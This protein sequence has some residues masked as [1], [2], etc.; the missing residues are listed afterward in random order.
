LEEKVSENINN[1]SSMSTVSIDLTQTLNHS[2]DMK[3]SSAIIEFTDKRLEKLE[4]NDCVSSTSETD[5]WNK[6]PNNH[7]ESWDL[8][9]LL[10]NQ[11]DNE[12]SIRLDS[13]G[14]DHE[15]IVKENTDKQLSAINVLHDVA[16]I[17]E[18]K[19]YSMTKELTS[20]KLLT[21]PK[22]R[23]FLAKTRRRLIRKRSKPCTRLDRKFQAGWVKK[24]NIEECWIVLDAYDPNYSLKNS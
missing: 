15:T 10:R 23:I 21:I 9:G 11:N 13:D 4:R 20:D 6:L 16:Q 18:S 17:E 8:D 22:K 7:N 19:K 1:T 3:D 2:L 5:D 12:T 24:Y 14:D